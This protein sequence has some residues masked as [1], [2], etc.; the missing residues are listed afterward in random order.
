MR[1]VGVFAIVSVLVGISQEVILTMSQ[2][3]FLKL[4]GRLYKIA[5]SKKSDQ[6][7]SY[8]KY[9]KRHHRLQE[10]IVAISE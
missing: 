5:G 2:W 6:D 4:F 9:P 8:M 1:G 10:L 7:Y 3:R